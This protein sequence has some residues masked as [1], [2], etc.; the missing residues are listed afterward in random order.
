[1]LMNQ[2]VV[3]KKKNHWFTKKKKFREI[4]IQ[5]EKHKQRVSRI[6][7]NKVL[8]VENRNLTWEIEVDNKQSAIKE[9]QL[10][11]GHRNKLWFFPRD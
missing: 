9:I 8:T 3:T 2:L 7:L 6:E 1:M 11:V 4:S 10:Y 5:E